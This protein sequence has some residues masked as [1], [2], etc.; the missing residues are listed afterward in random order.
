MFDDVSSCHTPPGGQTTAWNAM[1]AIST[2]TTIVVS[3]KWGIHF[4]NTDRLHKGL[5]E[6]LG[7][8]C[9]PDLGFNFE[10]ANLCNWQLVSI[11]NMRICGSRIVV[12]LGDFECAI[13]NWMST[14]SQ[15]SSRMTWPRFEAVV[16]EHGLEAD[17]VTSNTD[18][19]PGRRFYHRVAKHDALD[20]SVRSKTAEV[21]A[22]QGY[23]IE[24][25][26]NRLCKLNSNVMHY[27]T[28]SL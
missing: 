7:L 25:Q 17:V 3:L 8:A 18:A 23:L 13:G 1:V 11:L 20:E 21:E 9:N 2:T 6:G 14:T 28:T 5:I 26:C 16:C 19:N 27:G 22:L 4:C 10:Y 15:N 12:G 24:L